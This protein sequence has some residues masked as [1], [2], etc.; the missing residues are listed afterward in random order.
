MVGEEYLGISEAKHLDLRNGEGLK[1][2]SCRVSEFGNFEASSKVAK[3]GNF[4]REELRS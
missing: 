4:K 3:V 1:F 2:R